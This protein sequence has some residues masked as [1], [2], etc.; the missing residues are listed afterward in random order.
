MRVAELKDVT[1]PRALPGRLSLAPWMEEV[2]VVV[3]A[4]LLGLAVRLAYV[5]PAGF[6]LNDGG[7]FYVMARDIQE[8]RFLLP[9]TTSYNG[10]GIPF[11]YPPLAFY[12]AAA[13]DYAGPWSLLDVVRFL[14]L[15]TNVLAI[16]LF[17]LLARAMLP[18]RYMAMASVVVF[19]LLPR[20]F[21][22][23]IG[24]GGLTRSLGFLFAVLAL[25]RGYLLFKEGRGPLLAVT[26][27]AALTVLTHPEMGWL[28]AFSF[29]LFLAAYGRSR[30]GLTNALATAVAVALLSAPWWGTVLLRHGPEPLFSASQTGK[31]EWLSLGWTNLVYPY[32]SEEPFFP[33]LALLGYGGA[34][35]AVARGYLLLPVWFLLILY[36]DPRVAF[37]NAMLPLAMLAGMASVTLFEMGVREGRPLALPVTLV[38]LAQRLPGGM[39]VLSRPWPYVGLA[40]VLIY[41]TYSALHA[42][43]SDASPLASLPAE[44]RQA[45]AWIAEAT[46]QDARFLVVHG[47]FDPWTDYFSEW[48]PALTGRAS[49]ATVQGYEWLGKRRYD[50]QIAVFWGVQ[51]CADD[52]ADCLERWNSLYDLSLTHV[53]LPYDRGPDCCYNLR[54]SLRRDSRYRV[55][56]DGAGGTVFA[57]VASAAPPA[58]G[59]SG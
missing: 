23:Q 5:L 17:Y 41:G 28:V 10:L 57:R 26:V 14:P 13:L 25:W 47:R 46:P 21:L 20:S 48:F 34:L 51:G 59:A 54:Y 31:S 40:L 52:D 15:V 45:M 18:N 49:V 27:P 6:P 9:A 7:L 58:A 38:R 19:A 3:L 8:A 43:L 35:I 42:R 55:V 1:L 22:W 36:I 32:I 29:L 4:T 39:A 37:T 2:G 16:P 11:T 12:V 44:A 24:G 33:L 53:Y 50:S 30:L 56:Y